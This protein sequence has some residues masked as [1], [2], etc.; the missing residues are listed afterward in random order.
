MMTGTLLDHHRDPAAE[1][2]VDRF[3]GQ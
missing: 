2:L 1:L 3:D